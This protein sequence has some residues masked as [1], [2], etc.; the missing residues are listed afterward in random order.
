M[1]G[2]RQVLYH[3]DVML[4]LRAVIEWTSRGHDPTFTDE[5]CSCVSDVYVVIT[6]ST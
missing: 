2:K 5:R 1:E 6:L 4:I 3:T